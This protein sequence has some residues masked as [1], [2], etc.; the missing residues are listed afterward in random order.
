MKYVAPEMEIVMFEAEDVIV[1]STV[2][3]TQA[4]VVTE[5]PGVDSEGDL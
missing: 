5:A 4:P 2:E 3:P 1:A